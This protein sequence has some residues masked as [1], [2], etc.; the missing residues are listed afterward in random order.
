[1]FN[2]LSRNWWKVSLLVPFHTDLKQDNTGMNRQHYFRSWSQNTWTF[3]VSTYPAT[4]Y[5]LEQSYS[6]PPRMIISCHEYSFFWYLTRLPSWKGWWVSC[7]SSLQE[8]GINLS[9]FTFHCSHSL[10]ICTQTKSLYCL[11]AHN[12]W[13]LVSFI[14]TVNSTVSSYLHTT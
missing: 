13:E 14:T 6:A 7:E 8:Y 4:P 2:Q 1:M 11:S 5:F 12:F 3:L 9:I 10:I